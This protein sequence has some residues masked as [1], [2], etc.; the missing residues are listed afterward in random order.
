MK[1]EINT[2]IMEFLINN[3][4]LIITTYVVWLE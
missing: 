4:T 2:K 3:K 1:G